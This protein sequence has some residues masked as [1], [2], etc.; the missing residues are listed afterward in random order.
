LL[1]EKAAGGEAH[2]LR[3]KLV[4][5]TQTM[6]LYGGFAHDKARGPYIYVV[7]LKQPFGEFKK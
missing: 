2:R 4:L 1:K 6:Y 3:I 7:F 5:W